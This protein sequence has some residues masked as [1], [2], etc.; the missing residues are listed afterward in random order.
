MKKI[1]NLFLLSG[2]LAF[3]ACDKYLDLQPVG[4][5]I[6]NTVTEY[7]ALLA[8]A[9]KNIQAD[10]GMAGFRSD[11]MR[12]RE[13]EYD[14]A[15]YA[16]IE[17][18]NDLAQFP[19]T[20]QFN[21]SNYYNML[22]IA[23]HVIESGSGIT[24][25]T[26]EEVDQLVG[27]AYLLR[28]YVH[29]LLVNLYGQPYTK[30]G[31]TEAKA[32]PLKLDTD[33]EKVLSRNTVGE[34][35][36][37]LTSD[38]D[39]AR[40]LINKEEWEKEFS[41]RF[42][43]AS[44]EAFQ[45]RASLYMGQWQKAWEA[46]EAVLTRKSSLEDLNGTSPVLPNLFESVENITALEMG[47]SNT[48]HGAALAPASFLALYQE[49][50]LRLNLYFTAPPNANGARRSVK[51]GYNKFSSTFRVGEIYLNVAEAAARLNKLPEARTRLL[52]LMRMRYTPEACVGKESMVSGMG[53][54]AL[55]TEIL[56]ERAR[57]LAFEGHRWF[58]LRRT[59]RPRIEKVL[60][61][62]TYV[63]EQDDTRY[64]IPIP[65]EAIA[66]NPGLAN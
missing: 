45:S 49:G 43:T 56:N 30:P 16:D 53:Q 46:A 31:A 20:M 26:P 29:F 38:I 44:V 64:T 58:D 4:S 55:I 11:E 14:Q 3:T 13:D 54:E 61:G 36:A 8:R 19:A 48:V 21:W 17:R 50:D 15:N 1:I 2:L 41:Y 47:L 42:N 18:W 51:S 5:V 28:A 35:Y 10:R 52:Q 27:E 32:V 60:D 66:A 22:F 57:E 33:L 6:P 59:T 40:R 39:E 23:N 12:I 25:G 34:V 65:K 24:E 7:R 37:S 62:K 63:L 9:Y